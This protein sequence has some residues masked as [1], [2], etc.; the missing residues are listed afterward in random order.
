M[1]IFPLLVISEGWNIGAYQLL[2]TSWQ[3]TKHFFTVQLFTNTDEFLETLGDL[4]G[5]TDYFKGNM[6]GFVLRKTFVTLFSYKWFV[7]YADYQHS[8][9]N[10]K[11]TI[12]ID[13]AYKTLEE[14]YQGYLLGHQI[15]DKIQEALTQWAEQT[16]KDSVFI[17][18]PNK[19]I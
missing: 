5:I 15:E 2:R 7:I 9:H 13:A 3:R 10:P 18:M 1:I 16:L 12:G 14:R 4:S 19:G 8:P 6:V 11:N 17:K